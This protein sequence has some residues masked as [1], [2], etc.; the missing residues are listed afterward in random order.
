MRPRPIRKTRRTNEEQQLNE[1][2]GAGMR[3]ATS[4]NTQEPENNLEPEQET[5][6]KMVTEADESIQDSIQD[7]EP[8]SVSP[9]VILR[10]SERLRKRLASSP[11]TEVES[12][13]QRVEACL[14]VQQLC[15]VGVSCP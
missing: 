14:L 13:R 1:A 4:R 9:P 3:V 5:Q 10:R 7:P 15:G 6:P 8:M 11:L 2:F 12:K